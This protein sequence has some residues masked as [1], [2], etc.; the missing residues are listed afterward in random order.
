MILL[1]I[2][3]HDL[4]K[5]RRGVDATPL[6]LEVPARPEFL[7]AIVS[8]SSAKFG[9]SRKLTKD[10]KIRSGI[11]KYDSDRLDEII[12]DL[13]TAAYGL[14]V[15][16]KWNNI[17]SS[18]AAAFKWVQEKSGTTTQPH[19]CLVPTKW[20]PA[21]LQKWAGK[22][23]LLTGVSAAKPDG[24]QEAAT[25]YQKVCRIQPANVPFPAFFSR[26][27]FVGMYTQIMGGKSSIV[28]HNVKNGIAFCP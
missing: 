28:L 6:W 15:E 21:K 8:L 11:F 9:I 22:D 27:D 20:T 10:G 2:L 13:L 18:A 19:I 17:H 7:P 1:R 25:S 24:T 12:P 16:E 26:P 23:N 4:H 5:T 14:S 3:D